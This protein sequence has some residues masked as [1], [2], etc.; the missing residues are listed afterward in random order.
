MSDDAVADSVV[1][2]C[3]DYALIEQIQLGAIW[4]KADD[5]L[6][7]GLR[8]TGNAGQFAEGGV[9]DVYQARGESRRRKA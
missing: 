7:P 1:D 3:R 9:I 4:A 6:R 8:D 2:R 5:S